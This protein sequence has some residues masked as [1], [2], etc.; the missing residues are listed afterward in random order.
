MNTAVSCFRTAASFRYPPAMYKLG[1]LFLGDGKS[2]AGMVEEGVQL[3]CEA[4]QM[5]DVDAMELVAKL[6]SRG[7]EIDAFGGLVKTSESRLSLFSG[8]EGSRFSLT[9]KKGKGE[10][11]GGGVTPPEGGAG[12]KTILGKDSGLSSRWKQ[13]AALVRKEKEALDSAVAKA[14][15]KKVPISEGLVDAV[16]R[17]KIH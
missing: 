14:G 15:K 13:D 12:G 8:L 2:T 7:V 9:G 10:S 4:A 17:L 5:G 11:G 16:Q 1:A 3:V 6:Y